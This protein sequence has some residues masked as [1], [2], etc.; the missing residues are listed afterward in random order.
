LDELESV[1]GFYLLMPEDKAEEVEV[2]H[3]SGQNKWSNIK[4]LKYLI[5]DERI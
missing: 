4:I 1:E 3:I 2:F 5:D